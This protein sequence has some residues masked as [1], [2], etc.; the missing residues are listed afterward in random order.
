[1]NLKIR[2]LASFALFLSAIIIV[3]LASADAGNVT[4]VTTPFITIDP[5]GNQTIDEVFFINGTTNLAALNDSL[6]LQIESANANPGG[7]GSGFKSNV[8]VRPGENGIN[9][10]SVNATTNLWGT[11]TEPGQ[12]SSI[13]DGVTPGEYYV[14][15]YS[16][17]PF[18]IA[19]Q[20]FFMLS[21]KNPVT[22]NQ[23]SASTTIPGQS[24]H[25][26]SV[27]P[28]TG[29]TT[30]PIREDTP[31]PGMIPIIA[32]IVCMVLLVPINTGKRK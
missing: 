7:V 3:P 19:T 24:S 32:I 16:A 8:P 9:A 11:F 5:L 29:T 2:F 10:W 31:L 20:S 18:A 30:S 15:I 17:D 27:E 4:A 22:Q 23:T 14:N 1:M 12:Q 21:S 6:T 26:G 28:S 25:I 13:S